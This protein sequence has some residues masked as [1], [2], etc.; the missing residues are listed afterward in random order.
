MYHGLQNSKLYYIKKTLQVLQFQTYGMNFF[1][2]Y[3]LFYVFNSYF[4]IYY[5][6]YCDN[7]KHPYVPSG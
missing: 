3:Y 5:S 4:K 2:F 7:K 6:K 1:V